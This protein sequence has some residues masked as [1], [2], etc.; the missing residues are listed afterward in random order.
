VRRA[1]ILAVGLSGEHS[2]STL[3]LSMMDSGV[4]ELAAAAAT[5]IGTIGDQ[6]AVAPLLARYLVGGSRAQTGRAPE[7]LALERF[8][9]GPSTDDDGRTVDGNHVNVEAILNTLSPATGTSP[10]LSS[11][12][13]DRPAEIARLVSKALGGTREQKLG[14]LGLLDTREDGIGLGPLAPRL[15]EAMSAPLARGM[16]VIADAVKDLIQH[17]ADDNDPEVRAS[18]LRIEAKIGAPDGL[19]AQIL[20]VASATDRLP[21]AFT[22]E[23]ASDA[24]RRAIQRRPELAERI[25][26]SVAPL[27]EAPAWQAR[28]AA[29]Q[30]LGAAGPAGRPLLKTALGDRNPLVRAA[31]VE[32]LDTIQPHDRPGKSAGKQVVEP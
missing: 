9:G 11:L 5:A 13:I 1:A 21:A 31:A 20:G 24:T 14:A 26:R 12:W 16:A 15:R 2:T 32:A 22:V 6:C 7:L 25:V 17:L 4:N 30:V 23:P 8:V 10:D 19:P 3:L 29:V 27:L 18:A 28:W